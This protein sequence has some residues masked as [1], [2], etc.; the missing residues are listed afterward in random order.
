MI[1]AQN[2]KTITVIMQEITIQIVGLSY[3]V[4]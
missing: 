4:S 2:I 3:E 1:L